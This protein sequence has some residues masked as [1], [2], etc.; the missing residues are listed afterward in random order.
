M[1]RLE[2]GE[3]L[4]YPIPLAQEQTGDAVRP[5]REEAR[6]GAHEAL[7]HDGDLEEIL[8][9]GPRL[10]VVVV[11]LA[12][13]TEEAHGTGPPQLEVQHAQHETLSL[14]DFIHTVA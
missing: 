6:R 9:Q 5:G 1:P 11:R 10:K 4:T 3:R 13:A 2:C 8:G 7:V 12:D 14:E